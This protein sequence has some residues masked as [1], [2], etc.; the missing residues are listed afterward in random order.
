MQ[1][2]PVIVPPIKIE[3]PP[4]PSFKYNHPLKKAF[5]KGLLGK[6]FKSTA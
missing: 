6:D 1:I 3:P 2:M 4:N 5:D